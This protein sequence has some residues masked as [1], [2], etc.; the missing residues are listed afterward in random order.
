MRRWPFG[1]PRTRH[2][3]G[4]GRTPV[5]VAAFVALLALPL[6]T[7]VAEAQD[8]GIA[9]GTVPAAVAVQD[10]DGNDVDLG[11]WI[12]SKPVLVQF[13]AT[14]CPICEALEPRVRAVQDRFGDRLE[15]LI[16]AVGVN[17]SPRSIRRHIANHTPPGRV[18]FDARGRAARAFEAPS[19]SYI[20]VLDRA[21]R[22]VYT[23]VGEDQ[24]LVGAAE[25]AVR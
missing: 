22:T 9:I 21:G 1:F 25:K 3:T 20:V 13:W 7:S 15:I 16:I 8:V 14:W 6:F 10:L 17:Q 19:T 4:D 24:D 18:L 11:Q 2:A 5:R 12:G 23:G